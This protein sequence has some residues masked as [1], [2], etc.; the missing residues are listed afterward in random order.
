M[1]DRPLITMLYVPGSDPAKLG[2]LAS[3]PADAFILDLEDAVAMSEKEPARSHVRAVIDAL[4]DRCQLWARINP[5]PS[6]L[7]RADLDAVVTVGLAGIVAPKVESAAQVDDLA[8]AVEELE[9]ARGIA[10]RSIQLIATIESVRGVAEARSIAAAAPGR[11]HSLGFGVGDFTLDLG[12]DTDP[13]SPTVLAGKAEVVLASRLAGINP[14][15]DSV[16]MDFDDP[17]GLEENTRLGKRMGFLGKHAIHP[18]QIPVIR[19]VYTPTERE[20]ARARRLL[21]EFEEAEHT[22]KAAMGFE[23]TLVDYP[24]ADRARQ[25]IQLAQTIGTGE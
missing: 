18:K 20:V 17:D 14:P 9:T 10:E 25:I 21:A 24:I 13:T 4:G 12:I 2:K 7:A 22:G 16:Y 5:W 11:L 19:K 23:G 6:A 3:I 8:G 15:H 1:S